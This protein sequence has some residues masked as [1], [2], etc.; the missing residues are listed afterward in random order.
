MALGL[1]GGCAGSA[2]TPTPVP[3]A[4]P[5]AARPSSPAV[6]AVVEPAAGATVS[7]PTVHV[8]LSLANAHIASSVST[9][10]RPDEGHVHL[11]V[12]G[13]LVTMNYGLEQ[14]IPVSPG[15]YVVEAEFVASDHAPFAPRIRSAPVVFTVR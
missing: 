4:S 13:S 15:H 8:V 11:Y 12:D 10:L 5:A 3:V 9:D 2:A 1:L 7:G 14:D 6:I